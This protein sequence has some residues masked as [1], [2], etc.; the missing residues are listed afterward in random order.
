MTPPSYPSFTTI[1]L[2]HDNNEQPPKH[3]LSALALVTGP[4]HSRA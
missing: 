3:T 4:A 1:T 2:H